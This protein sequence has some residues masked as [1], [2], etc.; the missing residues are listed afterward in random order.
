MSSFEREFESDQAVLL[1]VL[2]EVPANAIP[3]SVLVVRLPND[4][5][6][7]I[8]VPSGYYDGSS[9][10][11]CYDDEG[12]TFVE[13]EDSVARNLFPADDDDDDDDEAM[14]RYLR[15]LHDPTPELKGSYVLPAEPL[16]IQDINNLPPFAECDLVPMA[17]AY[18]ESEL[19]TSTDREIEFGA[20]ILASLDDDGDEVDMYRELFL[21]IE[22]AIPV[23]F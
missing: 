13:S 18:Y 5:L 19:E 2:V 4:N 9:F 14:R 7:R 15:G 21:S 17:F 23:G 6:V 3:G 22:E 8:T 20:K 16:P 12:N 10:M 1:R 11:F